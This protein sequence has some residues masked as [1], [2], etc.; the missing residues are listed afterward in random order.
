MPS[1]TKFPLG[2]ISSL[3][4][5]ASA[6]K[7]IAKS[8]R[9]HSFIDRLLCPLS[10]GG[11]MPLAVSSVNVRLP[12]A[13]QST[14]ICERSRKCG[15]A[16]LEAECREQ[17]LCYPNH[18]HGTS[19]GTRDS[20]DFAGIVPSAA[21]GQPEFPPAL[22]GADCQRD[23][24]LVLH[25]LH[26]H[27]VAAV[28]WARQFRGS[29]ASSAGSAAD[30]DRPSG[31]SGKRPAAPQTGD[32]RRGPGAGFDRAG[33]APGAFAVDGLANLSVVAGRDADGG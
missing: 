29:G 25:A 10:R 20:V 32:D 18:S 19:T 17:V 23:W 8:K 2:A 28:D 27:S 16:D 15:S 6:A 26:L 4:A 14:K 13:P 30:V 3:C 11:Q 12:I 33:D 7:R 24:R 9:E 22:A 5:K 31:R 1:A 21:A